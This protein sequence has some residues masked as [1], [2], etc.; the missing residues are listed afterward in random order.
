MFNVKKE[1]FSEREKRILDQWQTNQVFE[2]SLAQRKSNKVFSFYDGPPFA[3]GLPHYGH[4]LAGTIKDVIPRYK[5]MKGFYVPRR[6][7]WDCHGLPVENEIEKAKSLAGAPA[8][9]AFGIANFNEEC[10]SIVLRYTSEWKE[11]V[12]RMGRWV[13]FDNSY[14]TMDLP[15]MES[16]WWVFG[17]LYKQGLVYQGFK[18]MPFSAKL[19]TPLSNFEAN[20]NYKDVDDPSLTIKFKTKENTSFLVWTTT[21]WTLP[22]NLA[23]VVNPKITYVKIQDRAT[24]EYYILAKTRVSEFFKD[25][26]AYEV[27]ET[28]LGESLKGVS[29]EPL[30]HYFKD[31]SSKKAFTV[32]CDPFVGEEDGTGIVHAAPSFGESD[33]LVCAKEEIEPVCPVDQNCVFTK[34]IP[35]YEGMFVK[36]ADKEIIKTLKKENKVFRHTQIRHRYPF[37]YRSDTPLIYK[38]V[39]TWFIAVEKIKDKILKANEQIEWMPA[40]IKHGRFGKWLENARDWAV[41]RNRYWGTPIPLWKSEEGDY[42]LVESAFDL[43]QKTNKKITDL[44]RHFIDDLTFVQDGKTYK[45]VSEVFDCWFESGSMPYAQHHY[46]FENKKETLEMFP[47]DFIAEGLDQTRGWFYTLVVLGAALFDKPAFTHA[48]VNGIVLAEDGQKMSKRLKNYPDPMHVIEKYGADAIRLYLLHSPVVQ[49]DDL[50][51]SERGVETTMRQFLLPLWNSFYFLSTYASIYQFTPKK[52]QI[53]KPSA[54]IDQWIISVSQKL[55]LDVESALEKYDLNKAIDPLISFIDQ[56]TNWYI[57]R[58]RE[59]FWS[60]VVSSDREEAFE[61][62]YQVLVTLVKVSAPFI[63]FLSEAIYQELRQQRDPSSVHLCDFPTYES[64]LRNQE[65][66][67]QMELVQKAVSMGHSLRKEHKMKVRQPLKCGHIITSDKKA[68]EALFLQKALIEDELNVKEIHFSSDE[69][70]FVKIKV[71]PN[72]RTVGK[73]VGKLMNLAK[74]KIENLSKDSLAVLEKGGEITLDLEGENF[75]FTSEDIQVKREALENLVANSLDQLTITLDTTLTKE[76]IIE[77]DAR[78]IINKINTLRKTEGFEIVDRIE[79]QVDTTQKIKEAFEKYL[80][81]ISHEVLAVK[82]LFESSNGVEMEINGEKAIISL[83]KV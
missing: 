83:K 80:D 33:F 61:T 18:V 73:K 51:F 62:L 54:L 34:Q 81:L 24:L 43:E 15:F 65:L 13:D 2:E 56:L 8:I 9:E 19:G 37:C 25:P 1:S 29:Y 7:G 70:S 32:L 59:R 76:L 4:L 38:T 16:V 55:V 27:I 75:V 57:R 79:I 30:F 26:A 10:R 82:V 20:L 21:P 68:L 71:T 5:A 36:D 58:S 45:R 11:T 69:S 53:K 28:F 44:H 46:P 40:H 31:H 66:E 14:K 52:E 3:T 72:F 49:A 22:S 35:E 48:I 12:A 77:G 47:A 41:S 39:T 6:F 63:P 23:L 17:Q 42:L 60:D 74:E 50:K 64:S 67:Y 78:E